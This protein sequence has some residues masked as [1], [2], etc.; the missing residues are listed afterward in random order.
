MS[1]HLLVIDS[2]ENDVIPKCI[3]LIA[4]RT[5]RIILR[6]KSEKVNFGKIVTTLTG[7]LSTK[8]GLCNS[9]DKRGRVY[10]RTQGPCLGKKINESLGD[11]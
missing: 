6:A 3:Q 7:Q 9:V 5:G 2:G 11:Q 8:A 4:C 1:F 10:Q